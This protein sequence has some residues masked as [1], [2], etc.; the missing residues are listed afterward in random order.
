MKK[1]AAFTL[2]EVIIVVAVLAIVLT[3]AMP[4]MTRLFVKQQEMMESLRL[5]EIHKALETYSRQEKTLP[6]DVGDTWATELVKYSELSEKQILEDVWGKRRM[7]SMFTEEV[8]YMGDNQKYKVYYAFVLSG[9]KNQTVEA[10]IPTDADSFGREDYVV[11][12]AGRRNDDLA[13]KY[14]DQIFKIEL[15]EET[16]R[17]MEKLSLALAKYARVQQIKGIGIH[18]GQADDYIY[19]PYDGKSGENNDYFSSVDTIGGTGNEATELAKTLGLPA[20]YGE[21]AISNKTMWYISNPGPDGDDICTGS[22]TD[23]PF[24][25]P[26]IMVSENHS[27]AINPCN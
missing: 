10:I 14:T 21:N 27:S 4:D 19:F 16:L 22:K 25:P 23:A 26:V 9:G 1:L 17:R 8:S 7:Y 11:N 24:Y 13:V 20:Y 18:K 5:Q 12:T 15:L 2:A 3:M 6:D